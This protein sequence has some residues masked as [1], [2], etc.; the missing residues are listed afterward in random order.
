MKPLKKFSKA[1]QANTTRVK[2]LGQDTWRSVTE[3]NEQRS[4]I[5]ISGMMGS[6]QR[7]HIAT[8]TNKPEVA[9]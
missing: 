7:G 2:I 5:K 3:I 9:S 1:F 4:H 8:F 6:F